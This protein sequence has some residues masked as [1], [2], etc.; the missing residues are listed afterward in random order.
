MRNLQMKD[1]VAIVG[2]S[3]SQAQYWARRYMG[4]KGRKQGIVTR[5]SWKDLRDFQTLKALDEVIKITREKMES[6]RDGQA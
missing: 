1:I 4:L 2:C 5:Y 6:F 3:M